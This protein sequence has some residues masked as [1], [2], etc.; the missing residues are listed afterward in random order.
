[1]IHYVSPAHTYAHMVPPPSSRA[2]KAHAIP[3]RRSRRL[4]TL[5]GV[6]RVVRAPPPTHPN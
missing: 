4:P 3:P 1:M 2:Y 5:D 6:H